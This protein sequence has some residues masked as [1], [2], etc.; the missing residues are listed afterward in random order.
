MMKAAGVGN[1]GLVKWLLETEEAD[2]NTADNDGETALMR[3][4][5]GEY[6]GVVQWLM[7]VRT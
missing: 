5:Y 4:A 7:E 2:V 3:T 1:Q 6:E